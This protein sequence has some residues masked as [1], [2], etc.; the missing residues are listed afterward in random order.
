MVARK[1][2]RT[3][4]DYPPS[5]SLLHRALSRLYFFRPDFQAFIS[6]ATSDFSEKLDGD[7]R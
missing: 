1:A 3:N 6:A 4:P 5:G 2:L 7:A